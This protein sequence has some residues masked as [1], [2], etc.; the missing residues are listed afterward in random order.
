MNK[1]IV[2]FLSV[3]ILVQSTQLKPIDFM[4]MGKLWQHAKT[5]ISEGN[6]FEEFFNMHYGKESSEHIPQDNEHNHLP[7]HHHNDTNLT[8]LFVSFNLA[9]QELAFDLNQLKDKLF[10]YVNHYFF[11]I[12]IK[13]V[14]PPIF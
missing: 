2:I 5:H 1:L 7:L 8:I 10:Y 9:K 13:I 4:S 14:Q 12:S 6:S 11:I 3:L